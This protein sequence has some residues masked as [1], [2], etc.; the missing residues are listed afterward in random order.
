MNLLD[1]IYNQLHEN[2]RKQSSRI[3]FCTQL[4]AHY[5]KKQLI[6]LY[7]FSNETQLFS[8]IK[9]G[10]KYHDIG[11]ITMPDFLLPD[12]FGSRNMLEAI[13]KLHP[14]NSHQLITRYF[15]SNSQNDGYSKLIT[16]ICIYHHER[17]D[18]SGYPN[19]YKGD[20]IP[21]IAELC[22]IAYDVDVRLDYEKNKEE[23]FKIIASYIINNVDKYHS[24]KAT[25]CF[26]FAKQDI[27]VFYLN[28]PI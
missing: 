22:S 24:K 5:V 10:C 4:M 20:E 17:Y 18:G 7:D 8:A 21:L 23:K 1:L 3:S 9:E 13:E 27:L 15:E 16:D 6:E 25:E 11:R 19:G 28:R 12:S 26:S 2:I 14:I